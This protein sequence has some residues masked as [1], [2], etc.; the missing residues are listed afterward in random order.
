V[1]TRFNAFLLVMLLLIGVPYYW[2]LIDNSAPGAQAYDLSI[3]QLRDLAG[4]IEG[5]RPTDIAA[6]RVAYVYRRSNW[7]AAGSGA[8]QRVVSTL[9]S[10]VGYGSAA[11]VLIDTGMPAKAAAEANVMRYDEASMKRVSA[12]MEYA[13]AIVLTGNR[14]NQIGGLRDLASKAAKGKAL[15]TPE[16]A[17]ALGNDSP[18]PSLSATE[19]A[20]IAPGIV[21]IPT[22]APLDGMQMIY[23]RTGNGR[24]FLFTGNIAPLDVSWRRRK[25][26]PRIRTDILLKENRKDAMSWLKTISRLKRQAP[27]LHVIAGQDYNILSDINATHGIAPMFPARDTGQ[28]VTGKAR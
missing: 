20:A 9:A 16:Q 11:P 10:R 13:R 22:N 19:P 6:E 14:V 1:T 21:T 15:L 17:K 4:E 18:E 5:A 23:V 12:V 3:G 8:R 28:Q 26:R 25:G 24:E 7:M 27:D 2:L